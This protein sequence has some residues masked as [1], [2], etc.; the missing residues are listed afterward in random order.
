MVDPEAGYV[1]AAQA[2]AVH[3]ALA[4]QR[5]ATVVD[6]CKV[7]AC[8]APGAIFVSLLSLFCESSCQSI[9]NQS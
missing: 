7:R 5:G 4:R 3:V 1:D 9:F 8:L 6:S 2:N